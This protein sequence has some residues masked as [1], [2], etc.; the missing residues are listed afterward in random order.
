MKWTPRRIVLHVAAV[1]LALAVPLFLPSSCGKSVH[2]E[3][4]LIAGISN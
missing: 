1:L 4:G 2:S 3:A